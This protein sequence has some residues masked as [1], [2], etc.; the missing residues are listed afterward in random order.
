MKLGVSV[1]GLQSSVVSFQAG[2]FLLFWHGLREDLQ[3]AGFGEFPLM[4]IEGMERVRSEQEGRCRLQD[5]QGSGRNL[6]GMPFR[7]V[8]RFSEVFALRDVPPGKN[9]VGK[10]RIDLSEGGVMNRLCDTA[11]PR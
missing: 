1:Q 8:P 5:V 9:P 3:P 6:R 10:I 2:I 7:Q 4:V 11:L